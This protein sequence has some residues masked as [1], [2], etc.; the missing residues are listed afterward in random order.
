MYSGIDNSALDEFL[1]LAAPFARCLGPPPTE[2]TEVD[3]EIKHE[4]RKICGNALAG[5]IASWPTDVLFRLRK[6]IE[7]AIY[8]G[9]T[10]DGEWQ[11]LWEVFEALRG[12]D[13]CRPFSDT[14]AWKAGLHAALQALDHSSFRHSMM[15]G[16]REE[17]VARAFIAL[18]RKGYRYVVDGSGPR[19][20]PR[21]F[22]KLCACIEDKIERVGGLYTANALLGL[23]QRLQ[24]IEDGSL[25]H[26]R[27]P[28]MIRR[29]ESKAG[30]PWHYIY[31]LALKHLD[32][33]PK[34]RN[35][36]PVLQDMEILARNLAA[37]IDVEPHCSYENMSISA[38]GLS[39][40]IHETTCYD[41]LFGFPQWQP[42]ASHTL[43]PLWLDALAEIGCQFPTLSGEEWKSVASLMMNKSQPTSIERVRMQ[44]I[45][46]KKV[47]QAHAAMALEQLSQSTKLLNKNFNTPF[48]TGARTS[49]LYPLFRTASGTHLVQPTA[50]A[51][52]AFC[53]RLYALMRSGS[54][55]DLENK[56]GKAL[57]QV[58]IKLLAQF[59][60][61]PTIV[62]G[63]YATDP[64]G[65]LKEVD[66]AIETDERIF[67]LECTK[68]PLTTAARGG[69]TLA[70]LQDLDGSFLKLTQQLAYHESQLRSKGAIRFTDGK[71]L[72]MKGRPIE[73]IGVNL[74][75]HGS[76]QNRDFTMALIEVMAGSRIRA[77]ASEGEEIMESIN[78]CLDKLT[79]SLKSIV[80]AQPA[81]GDRAVFHFAMST[82]WL[83]IDQL[84]YL[85]V[86]GNGDMWSA[87]ARIRHLTARSGDLV[88][89]LK[90][91]L[92][93]NEVGQAMLQASQQMDNRAMI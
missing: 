88:Y 9:K 69:S 8:L 46:S 90:R 73:K 34:A 39:A 25:L 4:M 5:D 44:D 61:Y 71:I 33:V 59:S 18:K 89:E 63:W 65:T 16:S 84:L 74:F 68:K 56:M 50:V 36:K 57:E 66:I 21:A 15:T 10:L 37:T 62:N 24:R 11:L 78:K 52:R 77:D 31:N 45:V 35:P 55:R 26:A 13:R 42:L 87:L 58:V 67:L 81:V 72:E 47:T 48:D 92:N 30:T 83:S 82:W 22:R 28:A 27:T 32:A 76:L 49:S 53:E 23:M 17:V 19:L 51:A 38:S 54:D 43:I 80:A 7:T 20:T 70:A 29:S 91:S 3:E 64:K 14:E 75:D 60:I 85:L 6:I 93:L 86:K 2:L 12:N 41:E 79:L 1:T 40:V